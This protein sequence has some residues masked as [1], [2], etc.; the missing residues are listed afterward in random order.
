MR[1]ESSPRPSP[2]PGS[3]PAP[4]L[5]AQ[6]PAAVEREQRDLERE[7]SPVPRQQQQRRLQHLRDYL[8][9]LRAGQGGAQGG[10]VRRSCSWA[11]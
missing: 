9:A 6:Q 5:V 1:I 11:G 7:D 4:R 2:T 8:R 3:R 10:L